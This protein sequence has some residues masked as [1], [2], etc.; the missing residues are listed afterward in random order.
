MVASKEIFTLQFSDEVI[1]NCV[2]QSLTVP[3][4]AANSTDALRFTMQVQQIRIVNNASIKIDEAVVAE[5]EAKKADSTKGPSTE[6]G[7]TE[8]LDQSQLD[9]LTSGG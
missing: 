5:E 6:N 3:R 8:S 2:I 9:K 4:D 7:Q 1:R